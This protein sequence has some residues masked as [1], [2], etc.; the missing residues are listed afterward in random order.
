MCL[1]LNSAN[2]SI[3]PPSKQMASEPLLCPQGRALAGRQAT[4][5]DFRVCVTCWCQPHLPFSTPA[6]LPSLQLA[7]QGEQRGV[8]TT[9][10]RMLCFCLRSRA[11]WE[12]CALQPAFPLAKE[13]KEWAE[14]SKGPQQPLYYCL[15]WCLPGACHSPL[16]CQW[17]RGRRG[18]KEGQWDPGALEMLGDKDGQ[19]PWEVPRLGKRGCSRGTSTA[20]QPH[21]VLLRAPEGPFC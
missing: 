19:G 1:D 5:P 16:C 4:A 20:A 7:V 14:A 13:G 21:P 10:P 18:G 2:H 9:T 8:R 3:E 11:G 15:A 6:S 12:C 17:M